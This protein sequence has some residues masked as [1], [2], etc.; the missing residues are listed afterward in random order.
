M[1]NTRRYEKLDFDRRLFK[2][3]G[4]AKIVGRIQKKKPI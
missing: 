1:G 3:E 2:D 4:V